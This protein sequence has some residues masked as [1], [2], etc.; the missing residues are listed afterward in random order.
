MLNFSPNKNFWKIGDKIAI[1]S[2]SQKYD[3]V[4]IRK[5]AS[6]NGTRVELDRNLEKNHYGTT[7]TLSTKNGFLDMRTEIL[8]LSRN[9]IIKGT[10]DE[11]DWGCMVNNI[12]FISVD[13]ANVRIDGLAYI[14]GVLFENCGQRDSEKAALNLFDLKHS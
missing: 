11:G 5:I 10:S 12:G 9:I 8:H 4:E 13:D 1:S 14:Q 7:S 6:V 3:Q 2:T